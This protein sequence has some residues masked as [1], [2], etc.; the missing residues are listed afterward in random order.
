M[1][2]GPILWDLVWGG[3]WACC[4]WC[5]T[6]LERR[7]SPRGWGVVRSILKNKIRVSGISWRLVEWLNLSLAGW[8]HPAFPA[9]PDEKFSGSRRR[10]YHYPDSS[11]PS[12]T[13]KS[14]AFR[15]HKWGIRPGR[16]ISFPVS[17]LQSRAIFYTSFKVKFIEYMI[18]HLEI[19]STSL[20]KDSHEALEQLQ[21]DGAVRDGKWRSKICKYSKNNLSPFFSSI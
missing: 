10:C 13:S 7:I 5:W 16:K 15:L 12:G 14:S 11:E 9:N 19:E 4:A 17:F 18:D 8:G 20:H 1:F 3:G 21:M 2:I 6:E